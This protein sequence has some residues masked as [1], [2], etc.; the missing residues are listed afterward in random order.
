MDQPRM[1]ATQLLTQAQKEYISMRLE[2]YLLMT[3]GCGH[4]AGH[5]KG[6]V[7]PGCGPNRQVAAQIPEDAGDTDC[8]EGGSVGMGGPTEHYRLAAADR[9]QAADRIRVTT[10]EMEG[11]GCRNGWVDGDAAAGGYSMDGKFSACGYSRGDQT[12][13]VVCKQINQ[14]SRSPVV[15][16]VVVDLCAG[17][18]SMKG[19]ARRSGY[20]YVAVELLAVIEALRS[21][22]KAQAVLDIS[23]ME[24][25]ELMRVIAE[26][27]SIKQEEILFIWASVP[28]T[29]LG[30]IDSSNQRPGYTWHRDYSKHN[31]KR[32]KCGTV[33]IT[34]D[35]REP[36]AP[37]ARNHD[38][39]ALVVVTAL[40]ALYNLYGVH[41]AIGNP[42]ASLRMRPLMLSLVQSE[43]V[44]LELVNYCQYNHIFAKDT[45]VWTIV[46][47]TPKG[48]SGTG[49]CRAAT[50]YCSS[51]TGF[52]R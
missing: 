43:R 24:P 21:K 32:C 1:G 30:S 6:C 25:E 31:Q 3:V 33:A 49:L 47:W 38:R 44:R 35:T 5:H 46:G 27:A 19:P 29:T 4:T 7:G 22:R 2:A 10:R 39:L 20:R 45:N 8:N 36:R 15:K 41:Y 11:L 13:G 51:K 42:R 34:G 26:Q 12:T 37:R 16:D 14:A 40:D 18:Q 28:C 52:L 50:G 9:R 48:A 17:R 23:A